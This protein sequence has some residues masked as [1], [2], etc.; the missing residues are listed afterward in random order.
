VIAVAIG[1]RLLGGSVPDN[2]DE[3]NARRER[4]ASP[5]RGGAALVA[6][7][8]AFVP[9]AFS[10]DVL[11]AA[12]EPTGKER[13]WWALLVADTLL[14]TLIGYLA[15]W[16]QQ[17]YPVRADHRTLPIWIWWT[18][19]GGLTLALDAVVTWGWVFRDRILDHLGTSLLYAI[20]LAILV[21]AT[22]GVNPWKL[23]T[24]NGR[25][26]NHEAWKRFRPALPLLI[27][28]FAAYV[29]SVVYWH[30]LDPGS[31]RT[32]ADA[33]AA[34]GSQDL[35]GAV[36]NNLCVGAVHQE[37]FAQ[38]SQVIPLLL[39]ALGVE[40]GF[41]KPLLEDPVS[42]AMTIFTVVMLCVGEALAISALP[43]PNEGCEDLLYL[44]HE[45]A[46]FILTLEACFVALAALVWA[47]VVST[48]DK[49]KSTMAGR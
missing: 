26:T 11:W 31:I 5:Q 14:L 41:F 32:L 37:Y 16:I 33:R 38:L 48:K 20:F 7:F 9:L 40:A 10:E 24:P 19:G 29:G 3:P 1:C 2:Q 17:N 4:E 35:A 23:L 44:L 15:W 21:A 30:E 25:A 8:I 18:V 47:L 36:I 39:V 27:G 13:P 34:A 46:A 45:Y 28:T 12:F 49:D 43:E 22:V 6:V 42:R